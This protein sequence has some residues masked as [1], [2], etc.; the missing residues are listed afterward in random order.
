MIKHTHSPNTPPDKKPLI[1]AYTI[2]ELLNWPREDLEKLDQ[3]RL[4]E[5]SDFS[6]AQLL[7][8]IELDEAR[9]LLRQLNVERVSDILSEADDESAADI[10]S[11]IKEKRATRILDHF[12]P[13]DAAD[14]VAEMTDDDRERLMDTLADEDREAIETL[15][16]YDPETAGGLMTTQLD[17]VLQDMTIDRAI[18]EIRKIAGN[19]ED[20]HY[21]YVVDDENRLLGTV[22]LR[23]LIQA[24]PHQRLADIMSTNISGVAQVDMDQERVAQL[25]AEL[26]LLDIAVVDPENHLLGI[27]TH[28][29]I[30]DV[31]QEEATE[32]ILIMAGAGGDETVHDDVLY[33][34]R[35]RQPWLFVNLATA[36]IAAFVVYLFQDEISALPILAALMPIIAGV[37][38]NS[39]QQ[40]LAV[41]IRSLALGQVQKGEGRRIILKQ[42]AIGLINGT[43]VGLFAAAAVFLLSPNFP[44]RTLLSLVVLFAMVLNMLTAG[45]TGAFVPIFLSRIRRDPAQSSSILLTAITDTGGFLIFLGLGSWLLEFSL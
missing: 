36:F 2:D 1:E 40:A 44:E 4:Q 6:I 8:R 31:V 25:M 23:K 18:T 28:D 35:K 34:V 15:L 27:I 37:G 22:S 29:D 5:T 13:D 20:L 39:G 45:L 33:S 41:A 10:L 14:I 16:T 7:E 11:A 43:L 3:A 30:L 12:D 24:Q 38:G 21:V 32:D 26:N 9:D 42:M 17:L 19:H